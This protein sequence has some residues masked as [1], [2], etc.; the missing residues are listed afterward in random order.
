[1]GITTR[2]SSKRGSYF[3]IRIFFMSSLAILVLVAHLFFCVL[4]LCTVQEY[5]SENGHSEQERRLNGYY[6]SRKRD[7]GGN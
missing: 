2:F 3:M 6:P 1:M 4:T 7:F 5:S